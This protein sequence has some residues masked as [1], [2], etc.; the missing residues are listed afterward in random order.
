MTRVIQDVMVQRAGLD[1]E[2]VDRG[3]DDPDFEAILDGMKLVHQGKEVLYGSYIKTH[4]DDPKL[5]ALIQHF[6]DLKRKYVRAETFINKMANG[7]N[8]PL[9]ELLDTYGDLAVY[10]AMGIQMIWHLQK[11]EIREREIAA[12]RDPDVIEDE[13]PF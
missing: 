13:I 3:V 11:R 5:M 8:F 4:G 12:G 6:C 1:Y 7:E 9:E 10:G 2:M